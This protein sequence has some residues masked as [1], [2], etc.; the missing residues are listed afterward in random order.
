M[1][2][3]AS[4]SCSARMS[5]WRTVVVVVAFAPAASSAVRDIHGDEQFVFNNEDRAPSQCRVFHAAPMRG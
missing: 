3:A 2:A 5:A 1:M 4:P